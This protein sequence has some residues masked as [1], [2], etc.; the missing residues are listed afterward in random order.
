VEKRRL[1]CRVWFIHHVV[2]ENFDLKQNAQSRDIGEWERTS[3]LHCKS[4]Y[5]MSI[6]IQHLILVGDGRGCEI[7]FLMWVMWP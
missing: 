7:T 4:R 1:L 6:T 3:K 2:G 5:F